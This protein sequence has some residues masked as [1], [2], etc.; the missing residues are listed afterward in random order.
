MGCPE[1]DMLRPCRLCLILAVALGCGRVPIHDQPD[2]G[3]EPPPLQPDAGTPIVALAL[4]P[5]TDTIVVGSTDKFAAVA[6]LPGGATLDVTALADWASSDPEVATVSEGAV[7]ALHAGKANISAS[8]QTF[9]AAA[10]L[11]VSTAPLQSIAV[12]P[13]GPTLALGATQQLTATGTYADGTQ[14]DLTDGAIW[15]SGNP[16]AATVS[17]SGLVTGVAAGLSPVTASIGSVSGSTTVT[18][19]A[20]TLVAVAVTPATATLPAGQTEQLTATGTYS[21]GSGQNITTSAIW[22]SSSGVVAV[23]NSAGS[24]GVVTGVSRGQAT[25]TAILQGVKGTATVTVP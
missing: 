14:V 25:V 4:N 18:V 2:S 10:T 5:P 8:Y 16:S 19:V 24:Q 17:P 6:R 9:T 13:Q 3:S 15:T 22:L 23:S 1:I 12:A 7:T 11:T 20:P 21:D